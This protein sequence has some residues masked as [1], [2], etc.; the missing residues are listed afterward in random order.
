MNI[1]HISKPSKPRRSPNRSRSGQGWAETI[2]LT[3]AESGIFC[4]AQ[5]H[6]CGRALL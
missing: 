1:E 4:S 6:G 3:G 5:W 2:A